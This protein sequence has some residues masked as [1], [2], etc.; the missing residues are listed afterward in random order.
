MSIKVLHSLTF[1]YAHMFGCN[2]STCMLC[3]FFIESGVKF[4][5]IPDLAPPSWDLAPLFGDPALK[6]GD[7]LG[8]YLEIEIQHPIHTGNLS[9]KIWAQS[10]KH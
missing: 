5:W 6:L 8:T 3:C 1:I 9:I 4:S 10:T 7:P 2:Y